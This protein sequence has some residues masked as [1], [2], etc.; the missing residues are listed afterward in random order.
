MKRILLP[1]L[2]LLFHLGVNA[3]VSESVN[4]DN[5]SD[6]ADH[7]YGMQSLM[8]IPNN[9]IGVTGSGCMQTADS[10]NWGNDNSRYC[11]KY[12]GANAAYTTSICVYYNDASA[13]PG[14][15]D[16]AASI[17]LQPHADPNHYIIASITHD[18][19][20][21]LL[22]YFATNSSSSM[23]LTNNHWYQISL[24]VQIQNDSVQTDALIT[25][26][27]TDGTF[28]PIPVDFATF[29][30]DD[31]VFA[32]DNAIEVSIVGSK[33]GGGLYV[34]NFSYEG[35]KSADSCLNTG[36][37]DIKLSE[38]LTISR[39]E[40]YLLV[41]SDNDPGAFEVFDLSGKRVFSETLPADHRIDIARFEKGI[42]L[43]RFENINR[44]FKVPL[45]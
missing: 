6:Q 37:S 28:P 18:K 20:V 44:T 7:F 21:E 16:R 1:A 32:R 45:M 24:S 25:D 41:D 34:D 22:S 17:W 42:Y 12:A 13:V 35:I 43:F 23:T 33:A 11:S 8:Q 9:G 3:Q 38:E 14:S 31:S 15:F 36:I 40:N 10:I 30:I 27:G 26:L 29:L 19:K 39:F 5:P 2:I 4:F